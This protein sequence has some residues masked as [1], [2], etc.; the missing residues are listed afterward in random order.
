MVNSGQEPEEGKQNV[1]LTNGWIVREVGREDLVVEEL[2]RPVGS[3]L[4]CFFGGPGV[5]ECNVCGK[6]LIRVITLEGNCEHPVFQNFFPD[7]LQK[8]QVTLPLAFC[9][10][11][12]GPTCYRVS[13]NGTVRVL[14]DANFAEE[15]IFQG[16]DFPYPF[17]P[18]E[19]PKIKARLIPVPD[20]PA[21]V[22]KLI[23]SQSFGMI[24]GRAT[25]RDLI[26]EGCLSFQDGES[27]FKWYAK[28]VSKE[29][30]T[31]SIGLNWLDRDFVRNQI[32][33]IPYLIQLNDDEVCPSCGSDAE[34]VC[35]GG[36]F[37]LPSFG[38]KFF[39]DDERCFVE[40]VFWYCRRCHVVKALPEID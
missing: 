35:V 5:G 23:F 26:G 12:A 24:K 18:E 25:L 19:F 14:T 36:F 28:V 40:V 7:L 3:D 2:E 34:L 13:E 39:P 6:K 9:P 20:G 30:S 37:G 17:Y 27:F 4:F 32:F 22:F 38:L 29:I 21:K 11:C 8:S 15:A 33:G 31:C 10:R 1:F 16:N